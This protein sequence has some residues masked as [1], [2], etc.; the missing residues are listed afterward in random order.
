MSKVIQSQS[1]GQTIYVEG[2]NSVTPMACVAV[3]RYTIG[4][5]NKKDG[6]FV[7]ASVKL[8]DSKGKIIPTDSYSIT[9][10]S[11]LTLAETK[12]DDKLFGGKK[13]I[14]TVN[15]KPILTNSELATELMHLMADEYKPIS[16]SAYIE[17]VS[18]LISELIKMSTP[19]DTGRSI[20]LD[21]IVAVFSNCYTFKDAGKIIKG[22][23]FLSYCADFAKVVAIHPDPT[24]EIDPDTS[25]SIA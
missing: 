1:I 9:V 12:D 7:K 3:L 20:E 11:D 5:P 8:S 13:L 17:P 19:S 22:S 25:G 15:G 2:A 10:E 14:C 21:D 18:V 4:E 24:G 16:G 6:Y 23:R